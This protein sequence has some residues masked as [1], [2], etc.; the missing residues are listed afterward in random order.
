MSQEAEHAAPM[1]RSDVADD[2]SVLGQF[3]DLARIR[4]GVVEITGGVDEF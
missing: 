3:G 1:E 4:V 2:G